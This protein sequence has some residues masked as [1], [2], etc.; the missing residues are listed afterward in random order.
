[1]FWEREGRGV[2]RRNLYASVASEHVGFAVWSLWSVLVLFMTPATGWATSAGDKFAL[3]SAV[4]VVGALLRLP[5]S[6]AVTRFGGRN[7]AV[8]SALVLLIPVGLAAVAM[9]RPGAPLWVFLLCGCVAGLGGGN[10]ASSMTNINQFFPERE[11][12]WA[13]GLN[14]GGGN[15]GV[16]SVQLLGLL[17]AAVAGAARPELLPLLFVPL[18]LG[19][20]WQA[21]RRMDNLAG[22]RTDFSS[23]RAV[24]R[25]R[26]CWIMS[27]L[28]VGTF[29]SFIGYS[30]AFGLVL[31]NDFGRTP[32]QAAALT[33][34]GPLLGSLARPVGGRLA[35]RFGGARVT[36]WTFL[37]MAVGAAV[38][39]V[40]SYTGSLALFT[41][42]FVVLFV[43]T[44]V[45]NGSTYKLIP[46]LY[47]A[48]A[49]SRAEAGVEPE[50]ARREGRRR[51]GAVIG[52]S[53]AVG[54]L[55]GAGVNLA[56]RQSYETVG[57]ARPALLAFLAFYAVCSVLTRAVYLRGPVTG[58]A[59]DATV[60][61]ERV[62][63]A[64]VITGAVIPVPVID[65]PVI[66]EPFTA[67][68]VTVP[69]AAESVTEPVAAESVP[70]T[71][72]DA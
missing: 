3:T 32:T 12:G 50:E 5:Y 45:G 51:A 70:D 49:R 48:R 39:L 2:A 42:G 65:P 13:L 23:Y 37:S 36:L 35:D 11:K 72:E 43:L 38:V 44:G 16:A 31:Q 58:A 71:R 10:F 59:V 14:A 17:M 33:F 53:G 60:G 68:P 55:G 28:Y 8:F 7:W 15:L 64:Q 26:H 69:V 24:L 22:T 30:F 63:P 29:G 67:R 46:A 62:V 21:Y 61:T 27:L 54:A 18:L 57:H 6:F 66:T 9:G 56:F 25:D 20:A 47:A 1:M 4:T 41:T 40:A 52:V 19:S 34:A